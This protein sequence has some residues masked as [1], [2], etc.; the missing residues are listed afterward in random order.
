MDLL[1]SSR[2]EL[3]GARGIP[4]VSDVIIISFRRDARK[5][6]INKSVG[7]R[8]RTAIGRTTCRA[9]SQYTKGSPPF[10]KAYSNCLLGH[11]VVTVNNTTAQRSWKILHSSVHFLY[12]SKGILFFLD[13]MSYMEK[14]IMLPIH[15]LH[16]GY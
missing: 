11:Q 13:L 7:V 2:Y 10:S 15:I 14:I 3:W 16:S 12:I 1:Q 9:R 6:I 4:L 8:V 5:I